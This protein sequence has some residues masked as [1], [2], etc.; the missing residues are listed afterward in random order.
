M[1]QTI[2]YLLKAYENTFFRNYFEI[3]L[4]FS[5]I[6]KYKKLWKNII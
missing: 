3:C 4:N 1:L 2:K 5:L 6:V